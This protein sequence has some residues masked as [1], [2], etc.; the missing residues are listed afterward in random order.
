[1]GGM[2]L[3]GEKINKTQV[4]ND[5]AADCVDEHWTATCYYN[6]GTEEEGVGW[7]WTPGMAGVS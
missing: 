4:I 3:V 2:I 7:T 5:M 1:M 6:G